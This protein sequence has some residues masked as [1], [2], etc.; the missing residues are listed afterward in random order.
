VWRVEAG[1]LDIFRIPVENGAIAG[2]RQHVTRLESGQVVFGLPA[3][4]NDP[5]IVMAVGSNGAVL[6]DMTRD[7]L[8][9]SGEAA[10]GIEGWVAGLLATLTPSS[11]PPGTRTIAAFEE[12]SLD[13]QHTV[14]AQEVIWIE[15]QNGHLVYP[16]S[17]DFAPYPV[18]GLMPVSEHSWLACHEPAAAATGST[19]SKR[20]STRT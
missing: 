3:S 14:S 20:V 10:A 19:M 4:E 5:F 13:T 11:P 15:S 12:V 18:T 2:M 17:D 16:S 6:R 7:Q 1:Y 9:A 8:Q